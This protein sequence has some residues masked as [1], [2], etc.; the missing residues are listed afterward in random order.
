MSRTR[1]KSR[2]HRDRNPARFA[3]WLFRRCASEDEEPPLRGAPRL[4]GEELRFE[5]PEFSEENLS[6][7][8][9]GDNVSIVFGDQNVEVT[10]GD[11]NLDDQGYTVT[12]E[13]DALV[14]TFEDTD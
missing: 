6:V 2:S 9:N 4:G 3:R 5:G 14:I 12:R 8:Q 13:A 1:L 10:L 11:R 7:T